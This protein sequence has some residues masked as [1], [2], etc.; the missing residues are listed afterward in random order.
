MDYE[1][2][3]QLHD[4]GY[5]VNTPDVPDLEELIDACAQISPF[6]FVLRADTL[7]VEWHARAGGA[8][9]NGKTPTEAAA[10]LLLALHKPTD[11]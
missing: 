11:V 1:L 3:Q 4:A 10:R 2:V 8:S 7:T 9:G 6:S 5:P